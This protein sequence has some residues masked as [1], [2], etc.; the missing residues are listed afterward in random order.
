MAHHAP[1]AGADPVPDYGH[2]RLGPTRRQVPGAGDPGNAATRC[3]ESDLGPRQ[4]P[5]PS[6]ACQ[7]D[8]GSD[9]P[10]GAETMTRGAPMTRIPRLFACP[11]LPAPEAVMVCRHR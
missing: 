4:L 8:L 6:R 10:G 1:L 5:G 9:Q 3:R 2:S 7:G 11:E